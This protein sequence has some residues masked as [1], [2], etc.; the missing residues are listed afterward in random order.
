MTDREA[1]EAWAERWGPTSVASAWAAWQAAV[2]FEREECA[3]VCDA[4]NQQWLELAKTC[5]VAGA[6]EANRAYMAYE[7]ASA[8]RARGTK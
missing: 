4:A 6:S 3:K 1:F 8:I 7:L 5:D 2:A